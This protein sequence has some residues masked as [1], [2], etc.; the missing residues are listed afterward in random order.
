MIPIT[1]SYLGFA[2]GVMLD[3]MDDSLDDFIFSI[4]VG[5]YLYIF[6][7]TLLPEIRDC[8]NELLKKTWERRPCAQSCNFQ[9]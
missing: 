3:T 9:E 6:L 4:S 1:L 5:M 2:A 7:G 8:F